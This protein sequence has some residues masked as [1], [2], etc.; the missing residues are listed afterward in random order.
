[1]TH[2]FYVFASSVQSAAQTFEPQVNTPALSAF[3]LIAIVFSLLQL[4]INS[5]RDAGERRQE[6][7]AT[8][9][10]VKSAQLA[11]SETVEQPTEAEVQAAVKAYESSLKEELALRTII[12]GVR[13]VAP[14]DPERREE[15][16]SAAK[17]FLGWDLEDI[18]EV[19]QTKTPQSKD[20]LLMQSRRRFDGKDGK[21]PASEGIPGDGMSNGA[22]AIL[23]SIALVQIAL[24]VVLSFDP[25]TSNNVFTSIAGEPPADIL[26]SSWPN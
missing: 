14:N 11:S 12:P 4:R 18:D 26:S 9:R 2:S 13:I 22:K 6:S 19:K 8:L 17:Q 23:F 20:E 5:V 3:L 7:L 10:Q 16:I 24:L 15:D 1:M 25:M 21:S